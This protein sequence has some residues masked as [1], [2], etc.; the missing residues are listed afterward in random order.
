MPHPTNN[1][2]VRDSSISAGD[3]AI[4]PGMSASVPVSTGTGTV[5]A[6]EVVLPEG[7]VDSA[8]QIASRSASLHSPQVS[9]CGKQRARGRPRGRGSG[10]EAGSAVVEVEPADVE[11]ARLIAQTPIQQRWNLRKVGV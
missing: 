3:R 9:A 2:P 7:H 11:Q 4:V 5:P 1:G 6:R 10:R 8:V